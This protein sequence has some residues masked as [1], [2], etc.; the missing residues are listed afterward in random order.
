MI[1]VKKKY[2]SGYETSSSIT[3]ST[4]VQSSSNEILEVPIQRRVEDI[5]ENSIGYILRIIRNNVPYISKIFITRKESNAWYIHNYPIN[6]I[7]NEYLISNATLPTIQLNGT[8]EMEPIAKAIHANRSNDIYVFWEANDNGTSSTQITYTVYV[9]SSYLDD[10]GFR[11]MTKISIDQNN[12]IQKYK[13]IA[14]KS[15]T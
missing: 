11:R 8:Q 4:L 9:Y 1:R 6:H 7:P 12:K 14:Y 5:N 13:W 15:N 3:I 2:S 10:D